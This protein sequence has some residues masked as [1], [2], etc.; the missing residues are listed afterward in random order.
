MTDDADLR[1]TELPF[2][3]GPPPATHAAVVRQT[4]LRELNEA[5]L[6]KRL[7]VVRGL[8]GAGKT[9]LLAQWA[10]LLR[11]MSRSVAWLSL[12]GGD[13]DAGVFVADLATALAG[14]G[15]RSLAEEV[16]ATC[17][18]GSSA[19]LERWSRRIA[20]AFNRLQERP[21]VIL[22]RF[23]VVRG[24][25]VERLV[26]EVLQ[27]ART[28]HVVVASRTRPA[29]PFGRLLAQN[30]L[31]EI[32]PADLDFT[33]AETHAAFGGLLPEIYT[34][35]LHVATGGSPIAVELARRSL[36]EP[37]RPGRVAAN[38][39]DWLDDYY[40]S[41]V[42]DGLAPD[43]LETMSRLVVAR[44]DLSLAQALIGSGAADVIERLRHTEGLLL[45]DRATREFHFPEMLR[46][47]LEERLLTRLDAQ[48]R[49]RLH[50]RA[51][52]WFAERGLLKE[53]LRHAMLAGER[54]R[55]LELLE[56]VGSTNVVI[57]EGIPATR[58]FFE[59]IDAASDR[60]RLGMTLSLAV[61]RAH[62][63]RGPEAV[64]LVGQ[65]RE[66]LQAGDAADLGPIRHQLTLAEGLVRGF[67]DE[68]PDEEHDRALSDYLENA[69]LTDHHG[70]AQA[71]ILLSWSAYV[72][73][74][75]PAAERHV[76]EAALD[77]AGS[78]GVYGSL[79]T[80]VH[81]VLAQYWRNDLEGALAEAALAGRVARLF[82]PEDQRVNALAQVLCSGVRFELGRF[83]G[84][85]GP[86]D[87]VAVV[88]AVESWPE[89]QIWAHR[90]AARAAA[91]A[92]RFDEAR[93]VIA[94]GIEIAGRLRTPRFEYAMQIE[95][96]NLALA[97]SDVSGAWRD[98]ERLGLTSGASP[99]TG[100]RWLTWQ[101]RIAAQ[102]TVLRLKLERGDRRGAQEAFARIERELQTTQ[103]PRYACALAL[104]RAYEH[105]LQDREREMSAAL[106][107][108][109]EHASGFLPMSLL[110]LHHGAFRERGLRFAKLPESVVAWPVATG[111]VAPARP[112][113]MPAGV[114]DPL[115]VRERQ[116]LQFMSQGHPNKVA[117]HRLGLSEATVKF[118][119]RNIY[120]K[121]SAQNRTQALARY[122][123]IVGDKSF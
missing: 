117:A 39:R 44:F 32:D 107:R 23:E 84:E 69:P 86:L 102:L 79:F 51:A 73:G 57:D 8:P 64:A 18:D 111:A 81:R 116:I 100:G 12:D 9:T 106:S 97:Q 38:W 99:T 122:R 27:H 72:R 113:A 121:L 25:L 60:T 93:A 120:R 48:E 19:A 62:E 22:D 3:F 112:A 56:R 26:G 77:Y 14:A 53:A 66:Q 76:D 17:V 42:L 65:V 119:L 11:Q 5:S 36:E 114:T 37:G 91:M 123:D 50:S 87:L 61:V 88:G 43:V 115:T 46:R 83:E 63:G 45:R 109:A 90:Y 71:H 20:S 103:V 105:S 34:R 31:F 54:E 21:I 58:A 30:Q 10:G 24:T 67:V 92:G 101:E 28:I 96:V 47:F 41:E 89:P 68:L 35:R 118:H 85:P 82:F 95:R 6:L 94:N 15:H 52:G 104:L 13:A 29:L 74:D 55:A 40:R 108:A 16:R 49:A 2:R 1:A 59:W 75:L 80:H 110:A 98:A 70:R 78:E 7:T 33:S 4:L